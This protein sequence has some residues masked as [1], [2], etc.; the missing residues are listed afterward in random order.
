MRATD[1]YTSHEALLLG[2][3]QALTRVDSTTG[4]WYATSGHMLWIGDR[5]R[6]PDHAHHRILPRREK[7]DRPEMRPVAD[8]DGLLQA[9]RPAQPR[10]EAGRLTLI[11]R[12]G[13][14]KVGDHLPALIRAVKAA[15][16]TVVW[17]C[18]PMHGN[19]ITAAGGLQDPPVR[20]GAGRGE[21]LLRHPR[22][23]RHLCRRRASGNDGQERHR[24]HRRRACVSE[25][26][27]ADRYDTQCDPRLNAEQSIEMAFLIADLLNHERQARQPNRPAVAAE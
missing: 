17:S 10:D 25:A 18:D 20:P 23:R 3:E 21:E 12:F 19:T 5:T 22:G 7:P 6:Q 2:Y 26:A 13:A 15:G 24:M 9:D 4:D 16:R 8:G 11:C 1:F 27:L 14:D